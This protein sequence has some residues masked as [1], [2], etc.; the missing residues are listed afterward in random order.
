MSSRGRWIRVDRA[1]ENGDWGV[2]GR[3]YETLKD[4]L[5]GRPDS[6]R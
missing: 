2:F 1:S 3:A 6:I 4:I 5:N